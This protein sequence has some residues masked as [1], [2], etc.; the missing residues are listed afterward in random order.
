MSDEPKVKALSD[1]IRDAELRD[2]YGVLDVFADEVA[3]LE[4]ENARLK[5]ELATAYR[6]DQ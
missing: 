2:I 1:R 3:A 5:Q 4:S 6:V